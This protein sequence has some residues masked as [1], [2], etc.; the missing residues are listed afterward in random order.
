M[1]LRRWAGGVGPG[2]AAGADRGAVEL[3]LGPGVGL[4]VGHGRIGPH[5]EHH[6]VGFAG[7]VAHHVG[8]QL[9]VP[10]L[11]A[12]LGQRAGNGEEQTV[13]DRAP[14]GRADASQVFQMLS[15]TSLRSTPTQAPHRRSAPAISEPPLFV[16]VH[17]VAHRC[18]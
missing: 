6:L 8:D 3:E 11:D 2:R 15:G 5:F 1:P 14:C 12:L 18:G 9:Q 16:L 17:S 10:G 4:V 7:D 13:I